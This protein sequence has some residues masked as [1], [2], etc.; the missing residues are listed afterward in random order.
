MKETVVPY[1]TKTLRFNS[2][3]FVLTKSKLATSKYIYPTVIFWRHKT[4]ASRIKWCNKNLVV[5]TLDPSHVTIIILFPYLT[6]SHRL[7]KSSALSLDQSHSLPFLTVKFVV[8]GVTWLFVWIIWC[9][10]SIDTRKSFQSFS[11]ELVCIYIHRGNC[12]QWSLW[13]LRVL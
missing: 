1:C 9:H 8:P 7:Q 13:K 6:I 10:V 3:L 2:Y 5:Q 4:R 12:T 11:N